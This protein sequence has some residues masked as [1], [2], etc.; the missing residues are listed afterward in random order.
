MQSLYGAS[1]R[2]QRLDDNRHHAGRSGKSR[3]RKVAFRCAEFQRWTDPRGGPQ[4][5]F[6]LLIDL[7]I[8]Q[9]KF[10]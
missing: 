4:S 9:S 5:S 7:P 6:I 2:R 1:D 3:E 8:F 10:Y